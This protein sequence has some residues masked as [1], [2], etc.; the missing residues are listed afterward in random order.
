MRK[1]NRLEMEF[2][3]S[4]M[5]K[6]GPDA[7]ILDAPCG[8]GRFFHMFS[9]S[10]DLTMLDFD[11]EMLKVVQDTYGGDRK[12]NLIQGDITDMP[13][14][15]NRFDLVFSMRLFHHVDDDE[16]RRRIM[17]ELTRVSRRYVAVSVYSRHTL[18]YWRRRI[19]GKRPS[20]Y[21]VILT[22]F[23]N[24]A[25]KIGLGL[26]S[27]YPAVS[28]I[29]QQRMLLFEKFEKFEKMPPTAQ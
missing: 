15:D 6:A 1:L 14:E 29:E 19:L 2:A 9:A 4:V 20:G 24:E 16:I 27:K 23:I 28:F 10:K 8:S 13:F 26:V 17:A 11:Q 25:G 18:R 22:E 7:G 21:S 5:E 3:Q 12:L